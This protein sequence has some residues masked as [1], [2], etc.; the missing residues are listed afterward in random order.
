MDSSLAS[1]HRQHLKLWLHI[2]VCVYTDIYAHTQTYI[3]IFYI[4]T[5]QDRRTCTKV[6]VLRIL[7]ELLKN[8]PKPRS[9]WSTPK[10]HKRKASKMNKNLSAPDLTAASVYYLSSSLL[11]RSKHSEV[12]QFSFSVWST[13]QEGVIL[14]SPSLAPLLNVNIVWL[15]ICWFI[16]GLIH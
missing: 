4:H 1:Y 2:Y 8:P 5:H 15:L 9:L 12:I 13:C 16:Q 7:Y 6:T 10:G 11:Q 3:D 14:P